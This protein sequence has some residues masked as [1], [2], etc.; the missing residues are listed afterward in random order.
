LR[1][2]LEADGDRIGPLDEF[3]GQ[4]LAFAAPEALAVGLPA[5][6][7]QGFVIEGIDVGRVT[8]PPA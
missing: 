2:E 6:L 4:G 3:D 7:G 5:Q 8:S 1:A